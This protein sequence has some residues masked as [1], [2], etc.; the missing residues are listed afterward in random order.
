MFS[1]NRLLML[2]SELVDAGEWPAGWLVQIVL[3]RVA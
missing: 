3:T 1:P 2:L